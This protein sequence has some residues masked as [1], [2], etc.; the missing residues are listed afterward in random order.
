MISKNVFSTIIIL[1]F[2]HLTTL[3]AQQSN[4]PLPIDPNL[5]YGQ[6]SNGMTYYIRHNEKPKNRADF[7]IVQKVG[8]ILEEENQR[9]LAHFLEHM[10]FNGSKHFPEQG[11]DKYTESIG[12]RM[13]E[14]M[15]AY[16]GF[17]ETVYM[18][19]NAPV[20]RQ[21]TVDSCLLILHDWSGFL[22]LA[23]TAI[24]KE[25]GVIREEW[26]TGQ[27]AQARLWEQQLPKMFP[28]NRYGHRMPI[29]TI[30][31]IN[32]F[33]PEELRDYYK[34]WYRPDLQAI[35]IV[36][37]IDVAYVESSIQTL[38]SDIPAPNDPAERIQFEVA[39]NDTPL[40]SI[41]KDKE[42]SYHILYLFFKH[43]KLPTEVNATITGMVMDYI[44]SASAT[45]MNDRFDEM[46]LQP[47]PPFI[48]AQSFDGDYMVAR[49]KAA[50]TV[51]AIAEE[52]AINSTLSTLVNETE[53][54]RQYGFT[55]SEYERAKTNILKQYESAYNE[56]DNQQN[57][58]Y[59]QEYVSHFTEGGYTPGIEMEYAL[60][61]QIAET[62]TVE[63]INAYISSIIGEKNIVIGLTGPDKE[64]LTYPTE[65]ELLQVFTEARNLPV[66]PYVENVSDEPLIPHLPTPGTIVREENDPLFNA[67]VLTLNN[68]IKVVLKQTDFKKDQIL[69]TATRSGGTTLFDDHDVDNLKVI[70][71]VIGLGGWGEFSAIDLNKRLAGKKVSCSTAIGTDNESVN[72]MAA[73]ADVET[74]FQLIYLS[75]TAPRRDDDAYMSYMTRIKAQLYNLELDPMVSFSDTLMQTVYAGNPRTQRLKANDFENISYQR[76]LQMYH[77]RFDDAS[78][79]VFTFVGNIDIE[80]IKPYIKQ[81]LASLPAS[82]HIDAPNEANFP[83]IQKGGI[84]KRFNRHMET[85]KASVISLYSG[86]MA[87]TLENALTATILKQ[88]LDLVYTEKIRKEE[89]ATYGVQTSARVSLFPEGRTTLQ[90]YF[91]T[92]PAR[93]HEMNTIIRDELNRITEEG[94]RQ[95]D[96]QK[97][98]D[99]LFKRYAENQEENSYWL[100]ILDNY[101][102]RGID[103]YTSYQE[104]LQK[105]TP[106]KV[107][108]FLKE[109]ID[110]ENRIELIMEP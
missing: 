30:D 59:S 3:T 40:V 45:M 108:I 8:S 37:D 99:N 51:T 86:Q 109:L 72:G 44:R 53:R 91:D 60:I 29:G 19:M 50:W 71:D 36:G 15:N 69:M 105:L 58:S 56:R 55:P 16:T 31:V 87:Y 27:D 34:K 18:L 54:M 104:T 39:D 88:V 90:I 61:Q 52:G 73:P 49:T 96:F 62:V 26:R 33:R 4:Q 81:Y 78:G 2:V 74:L 48:F 68:G 17:D 101:Y 85:P 70:N 6:L 41:A 1:C 100:N 97:T 107:R 93:F 43:D 11:M 110:Q 82:G 35:I 94:P 5:R 79:F 84:N 98:I 14:N 42:A 57:D 28:D 77:E 23:D 32:N 13:G 24:E 22:A 25:R 89:G 92:D 9:G 12:M 7:Y 38:F 20:E 102:Y 21:T 65:E 103:S 47:T 46:V 63:Q 80:E 76:L 83:P 66:E 95:E 75:F 106:D 67:H 64:E 10:A